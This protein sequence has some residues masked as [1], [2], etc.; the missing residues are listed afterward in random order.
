MEKQWRE[1]GKELGSKGGGNGPQSL[2][3]TV[4]YII[5][6]P[7]VVLIQEDNPVADA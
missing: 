4:F 5:F 2:T 7:Y 6:T 3:P 1:G